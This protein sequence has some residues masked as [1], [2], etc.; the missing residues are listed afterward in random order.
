MNDIVNNSLLAAGE[1]P[2]F[3]DF[4]AA[5]VAPAIDVLIARCEAALAEA[6]DPAMPADFNRL[7]QVL[8]VPLEALGEAWGTVMHLHAVLDTPTLRDAVAANQ[9]KV[10]AFFAKLS[11]DDRL[12]ALA[13]RISAVGDESLD[14]AQFKAISDKLR[15]FRLA[16]AELDAPK[17]D[18]LVEIQKSLSSLSRDFS[19]HVMDATDDFAYSATREELNGVPSD[20]MT[21]LGAAADAGGRPGAFNITLHQ[22]SLGPVMQY[23][24]SREL[25]EA[26][27]RA[28][29]TRASEFGP[30]ERDN[31]P[32]I[33]K[34]LELRQERASLL[35]LATYA[36]VSLVPKM[37][38]TPAQVIE[39]LRD[40]SRRAHPHAQRDLHELQAFARERLGLETLAAWD[41][42]YVTEMLRQ[43]RYAFSEQEVKLHFRLDQ[44]LAGMFDIAQ[45]LFGVVIRPEPVAA[46]HATVTTYRIDRGGEL[47]GRFYLDPFARK[48]KRGG[49]WM[50][51]SQ[52]RWRKPDGQ[53]RKA[54][55]YL[56][57]NFA[58]PAPG[59]PTL[60]RH[61][62][63]V[64]LFHEFG[65]GLHFLL[66]NVD[67]L[68]VSGISGVEWDAIELPSQL[69]ENFA[70][71]WPVI[72]RL[73]ANRETGQALPRELFDKMTEAR[74]FQIGLWLV[75]QVEIALFDMR[76]HAEPGYP[77]G[78]Q[79]LMDDVRAEVAVI[80]PP[81]FN[82]FQNAF[83]HAFSGSY[84]A[85]YYSYLWAEVL[86]SDAWDA[87]DEAGVTD[88][89]TG[90]RYLDEI[91][92][93]GG[94][95]PMTES[96]EAFR[97]RKPTIDA[98]LRQRG[99]TEST[100]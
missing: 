84:A 12:F 52:P 89:V 82:R 63:V 60:L 6:T 36:D 51:G 81:P 41:V 73:T 26:L 69:M 44:V 83:S 92:A 66:S 95:R 62:E 5:E 71:E 31:G 17:K 32:V 23:A 29:A 75:R 24:A 30:A 7:S 54:L 15:S 34:I 20:V 35:G 86:A 8:D 27:Y 91:L 13:K 18:R 87:F 49:A 10:S 93:R 90:Q 78:V 4:D 76:L 57:T 40:I 2:N 56:V 39:F 48:G 9:P 16:G 64:T 98:L 80:V 50:S 94:S 11:S 37:A 59:Q 3:A 46:W 58:E 53:L 77:G 22:P 99:L 14:A 38:E 28:N 88:V 33:D 47:L 85:G 79:R 97:G 67:V 68:G 72:E 19:N 70:W 45:Q 1:L 100:T 21:Q 96:F 74:N 65:H 61:D 55:A 43:E 42:A 25:R